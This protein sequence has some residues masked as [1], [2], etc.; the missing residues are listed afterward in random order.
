M[1]TDGAFEAFG[2][3]TMGG[4]DRTI[5]PAHFANG[6]FSKHF[7]GLSSPTQLSSRQFG[8]APVKTRVG[9]SFISDHVGHKQISSAMIKLDETTETGIVISDLAASSVTAKGSKDIMHT[10]DLRPVKTRPAGG[11][12]S[13]LVPHVAHAAAPAINKKARPPANQLTTCGHCGRTG[14]EPAT[15]WRL[16]PDLAPTRVT[17]PV[18]KPDRPTKSTT[19]LA[20]TSRKR[21]DFAA[22]GGDGILSDSLINARAIAAATSTLSF[23]RELRNQQIISLNALAR[24]YYRRSIG[25][26]GGA[27]ASAAD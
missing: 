23:S 8:R 7:S 18:G 13:A 9:S 1:Y 20:V 6:N 16:H 24:A 22:M 15:C 5:G 25:T 10:A 21:E 26:R 17:A 2:T 11:P 27:Q 14:H 12:S 19:L 4:V 3:N